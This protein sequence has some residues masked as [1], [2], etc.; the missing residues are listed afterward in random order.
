MYM[1]S[2]CYEFTLELGRFGE[3]V[4]FNMLECFASIIFQY[5]IYR[6]MFICKNMDGIYA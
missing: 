1:Y 3:N 2:L 5:E 4:I 6:C